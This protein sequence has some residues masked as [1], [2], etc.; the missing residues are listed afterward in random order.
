M[1]GCDQHLCLLGC[2]HWSIGLD[3]DCWSTGCR[4]FSNSC[5]LLG[6]KSGDMSLLVALETE[7]TLD[8]LPLFFV[9]DCGACPCASNVHGIWVAIVEHVSPLKLCCSSSSVASFNPL[10]EVDVLLLVVTG[11]TYPVVPCDWVV[12]FYTIGD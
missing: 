6:A 11:G 2:A 3:G 5:V 12:E 8:S 4:G 9:C 1:E 7:S 10:F